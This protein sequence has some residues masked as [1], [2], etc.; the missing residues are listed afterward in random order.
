[1][2]KCTDELINYIDKEYRNLYKLS[3][4]EWKKMKICDFNIDIF[5]DTLL[6]CIV[7]FN[8]NTDF[9]DFIPY[10]IKAF[11]INVI[12]EDAYHYKSKRIDNSPMI[13]EP[14]SNQDIETQIDFN[15]ILCDV[16]ERF[17]REYCNIFED[18]LSGFTIKELN[19]MYLHINVRYVI[20]KIRLY[21]KQRR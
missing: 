12:R 4:I 5:H 15:L 13:N 3:R 20:D 7:K 1:M 17:G 14:L 2:N 9:N 19:E 16:C 18:W 10:F 8:D 11:R 21:L 6:K